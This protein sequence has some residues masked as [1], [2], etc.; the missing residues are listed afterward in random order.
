MTEPLNRRKD[1]NRLVSLETSTRNLQEDMRNRTRE[2]AETLS[3]L[4]A[5]QKRQGQV[6]DENRI[7]T[8]IILE[9]AKLETRAILDEIAKVVGVVGVN[10]NRI[11]SLEV[12]H[13]WVYGWLIA[14]SSAAGFIF[15]HHDKIKAVKP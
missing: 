8:K 3:S 1:D 7:G 14:L 15:Q 9:Q 12:H 4:N 6:I 2:H 5:M 10:S 13:N 11:T